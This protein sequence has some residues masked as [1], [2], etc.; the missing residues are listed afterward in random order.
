MKNYP[1]ALEASKYKEE[2]DA[3]QAL[4]N[5]VRKKYSEFGYTNKN[6]NVIPNILD[7][8]FEIDHKSDFSNPIQLLYVGGLKKHKGVDRLPTILREL[9]NRSERKFELSI[10]GKGPLKH[11]LKGT[12]QSNRT[13]SNNMTLYGFVPYEKLPTIYA[14]HDLFVYP[15]RWHEPFGRVFLESL[16]AR[17]PVVSTDV[18]SVS[19]IIGDGGE[20]GDG[21]N[22]V[23][24]LILSLSNNQ[25]QD[26]SR[27]AIYETNKF[28]KPIVIDKINNLYKNMC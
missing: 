3:F 26:Y 20:V 10:V 22:E 25:L 14:N 15:G 13:I 2:I 12:S 27:K 17:T 1:I 18:G 8:R 11:Y 28:K 24:E 21:I 4:S 16:A 6:I 23:I 5:H 19:E 9:N 7:E